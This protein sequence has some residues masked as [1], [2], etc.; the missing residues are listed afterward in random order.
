[1][2]DIQVMLCF[3]MLAS[4]MMDWALSKAGWRWMVGLP[5]IPGAA[6]ALALVLLPESPRW[7][8][9]RGRLDE[10]LS[11]LHMV[12]GSRKVGYKAGLV[13]EFHSRLSTH[14]ID[15]LGRAGRTR[16]SFP[17]ASAVMGSCADGQAGF[18]REEEG[19]AR[20][21]ENCSSRGRYGATTGGRG[22]FCSFASGCKEVQLRIQEHEQQCS[23][24]DG[25]D[26]AC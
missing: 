9:M 24:G 22:S 5:A 17:R 10:A 19:S 4:M 13:T 2:T 12:L 1:M 25:D 16:G 14:L 20:S 15:L 23:W 7:L 11:T 21:R 6:M 3:G 18:C 8:V 26:C